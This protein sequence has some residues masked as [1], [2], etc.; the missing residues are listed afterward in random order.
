MAMLGF[1]NHAEVTTMAKAIPADYSASSL[2]KSP[3]LAPTLSEQ[4]MRAIS[5][6]ECITRLADA[7]HEHDDRNLRQV[8]MLIGRLAVPL[9]M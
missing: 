2:E 3:G 8:A 7:V 5:D 6:D 9:E 4:T 1:S